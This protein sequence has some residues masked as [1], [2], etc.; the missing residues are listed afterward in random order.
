MAT[1]SSGMQD[2]QQT[3]QYCSMLD[4][5]YQ[6]PKFTWCNRRN[7]DLICKKLDRALMNDTW[8]NSFPQSY[9]VFEAGRC[10]DHL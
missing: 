1:V 10:S 9:C 7:N 3:A 6:G 2:F 8:I 5:T 4:M